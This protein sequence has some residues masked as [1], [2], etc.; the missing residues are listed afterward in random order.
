MDFQNKII[1]IHKVNYY[2]MVHN[3]L[4]NNRVSFLDECDDPD[5]LN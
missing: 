1:F 3:A 4:F 2:V 5:R